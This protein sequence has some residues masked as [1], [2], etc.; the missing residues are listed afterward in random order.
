MLRFEVS[1]AGQ[2]TLPAIDVEENPVVIGSG[3]SAR[4]RLPVA[5]ARESHV[6]F[7]HGKWIAIGDVHVDGKLRKA[8]DGGTLA[9]VTIFELGTYHIRVTT[10]PADVPATSSQ[11]TESIARELV[12]AMLGAGAAPTFEIERGPSAGSTRPLAPP[13]SRLV[14]GRGDE[15]DWVILDEDLSRAH[16][17][18]RRGWDGVTIHDRGSKNGTHVD[19]TRI[20]LGGTELH[21]GATITLGNVTLRFRDPAE[22]HLAGHTPVR[23]PRPSQPPPVNVIVAKQTP[24]TPIAAPPIAKPA[25]WPFFVAAAIAAAAAVGLAYVLAS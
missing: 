19:G 15:A 13:E 9:E 6:R 10:S 18:V 25:A 16:A 17:E 21:D 4:L 2:G 7:D 23:E 20:E 11:R 8:G 3:A 1:E 12:R 22:R 5:I 24:S 14:I